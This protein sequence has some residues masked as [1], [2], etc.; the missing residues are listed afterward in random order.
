MVH[1]NGYST[2]QHMEIALLSEI[3][4]L[5]SSGERFEQLR[6]ATLTQRTGI[7]RS[8]FYAHFQDKLDLMDRLVARLVDE[9]FESASQWYAN[10]EQP[11]RDHLRSSLA[12]MLTVYERYRSLFMVVMA[13]NLEQQPMVALFRKHLRT[14]II[15]NR[16]LLKQSLA[17]H[18]LRPALPEGVMEVLVLMVQR[19]AQQLPEAPSSLQ[20]E[21]LLDA[22]THVI[23]HSLFVD[24][25]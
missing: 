20:R 21:A 10:P 18:R 9:L 5:L 13:H 15:R 8:T 16:R 1:G 2:R 11:N 3:E 25:R 14:L 23:W 17:S 22:W 19:G 4:R 12:N 7:P 6:I 24:P